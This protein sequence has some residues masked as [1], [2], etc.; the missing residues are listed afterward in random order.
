MPVFS[1]IIIKREYFR[2]EVEANSKEEARDLLWDAEIYD[3]PVDIDWDISDEIQ[4]IE[5]AI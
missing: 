4:E 3:E 1:G 5:N 2:V